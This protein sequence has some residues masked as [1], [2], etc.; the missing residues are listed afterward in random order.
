VGFVPCKG[1][2]APLSAGVEVVDVE[3][4]GAEAGSVDS[5]ESAPVTLRS[6]IGQR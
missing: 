4:S 5:V 2:E 3:L 1:E 6:M